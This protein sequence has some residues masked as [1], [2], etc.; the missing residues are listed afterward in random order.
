MI[1]RCCCL[2][3]IV[4]LLRSFLALALTV[5]DLD[6]LVTW[7]VRTLIITGNEHFSTSQL[8]AEMVTKTRPWYT[9]WRSLPEFDPVTFTKDVQR[10]QRFYQAQGYYEAHVTYDLETDGQTV[11]PR[12]IVS[13]ETPVI[14]TQLTV[15][16]TDQPDLEPGVQALRPSLALHEGDI[17]SEERYQQAE[18]KIKEFFLQQHHGWVAVSRSADVILDEH[19]ARVHYTVTAGAV[20]VFGSTVIEG[21]QK[22]APSLVTR[23]F[24]YQPGTPFSAQ[25]IEK[26][27]KNLQQL[28][29][30]SSIRFLQEPESA[31]ADPQVVPMRVQLEEKPVR[32]WKLG[33]GYGTEDEFRG[34]VRWRHNNWFGGGRRFAV[35]VEASSLTRL[36]DVSFVQPY[37]FGSKNRFSLTV[38]P[39]Q[40][41]EPGYLLNSTQLQP[42]IDREFTDTLSGFLAYRAEYDQLSNINLATIQQLRDFRRKGALSGVAFGLL[43]NTTDDLLNPTRGGLMSIS[44]EQVGGV[45]GGDFDF[46]KLQGE[47]KRYRLVMKQTILAARLR[48]GFADPFAGGKEVPLFERFFAGGAASVRG[49]GRHRLGPL[50]TADDPIGGRS[51]LEGSLELRRPLFEKIGGA[52]FLDFGQVSKRSFDVPIDDLRF[53]LGFGVSYTTAVGPLR[54]DLGFPLDPPRGD[55]PWQ[56][57]F[58]IG[59]FF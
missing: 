10:L 33:I 21:L 1:K 11:I 38:R 19:A 22:V 3:V 13:E 30:F 8:R 14:V 34:Q 42:R 5:D 26:S 41:D 31:S 57:H 58:S 44:A 23:E 40:I 37:V 20:T 32:E 55:Q 9:L 36:I 16:L 6:P 12:I 35:Q 25:A 56:V 7:H 39:Q 53:A 43:W 59:Q 46:Y 4:T 15:Q 17:F 54:L 24:A 51:L 52:L 49:Y 27:R 45:L 2:V 48:L 47:L 50:S 18:A 29:L 28:D